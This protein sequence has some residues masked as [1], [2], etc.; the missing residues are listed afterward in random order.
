MN[1]DPFNLWLAFAR[2]RLDA[3]RAW[4][5]WTP[6]RMAANGYGLSWGGVFG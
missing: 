3:Y 6:A 5:F 1:V 2:L 4:R